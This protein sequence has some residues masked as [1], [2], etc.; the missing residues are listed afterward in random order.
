MTHDAEPS[1]DK[2]W[3]DTVETM[4]II[5]IL[6]PNRYEKLARILWAQVKEQFIQAEQ[7]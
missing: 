6:S 2:L 1:P 4:A 3:Q 7:D 5:K